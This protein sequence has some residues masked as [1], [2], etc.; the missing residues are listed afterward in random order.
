MLDDEVAHEQRYVL[1]PLPK[2]WKVDRKHLQP[3]EQVGA[4]LARLYE[5]FERTIRGSDYPNVGPDRLRAAGVW[6]RGAHVRQCGSQRR[7]CT[8]RSFPTARRLSPNKPSASFTHRPS[9]R[10]CERARVHSASIMPF[11]LALPGSHRVQPRRI[12]A[13]R[14]LHDRT[15]RT[16]MLRIIATYQLAAETGAAYMLELKGRLEGNGV[17]EL[18]R[19]WRPLREAIAK[20]P[21]SLAVSEVEFVDAAGKILLAEMHRAQPLL[22]SIP[23]PGGRLGALDGVFD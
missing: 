20:V 8:F 23:L 19:T 1:G 13:A 2:G 22:A 17:D 14:L 6:P 11:T 10:R 12:E 9:G 21:V 4:K 16:A 3:I 5:F 7:D 18:R 15:Q